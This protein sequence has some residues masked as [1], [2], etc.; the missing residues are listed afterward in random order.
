MPRIES[1][2][3]ITHP[4]LPGVRIFPLDGTPQAGT[5]QEVLVD[6]AADAS[7]ALHAH[8]CDAIMFIVSGSAMVQSENPALDG[9]RVSVGDIVHFE[10]NMAHGFASVGEVFRFISRNKGIVDP[11]SERWDIRF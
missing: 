1:I 9:R 11:R 5:Q 3:A 7:I 4:S 2:A 6:V 10:A 8:D